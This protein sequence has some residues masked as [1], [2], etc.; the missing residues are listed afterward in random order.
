MSTLLEQEFEADKQLYETPEP[1]ELV[2]LLAEYKTVDD[3]I[4]AAR[5]VRAA[6]F[7]RWDVHSPF[8]I[9][10]I[11]SVMGIRPTIL[12]WLVLGGGL[13]GLIG[14]LGLQWYCNAFDYPIIISGKPFWS[15]PANIPIIFECTVLLAALTAVFG[16]FA[17]NQLPMLYNPLFKSERF[18][19]VTDDRFFVVIDASDRRFDEAETAKLLNDT[20]AIAIERVED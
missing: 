10:G 17:L 20:G 6:G 14:G 8:P 11:D 2:G 3:V 19:R 5:A 12:P 1:T 15:L 13:T 9:H 18:R 4:G 7:T 16:M